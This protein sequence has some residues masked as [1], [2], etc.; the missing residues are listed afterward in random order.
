M[1]RRITFITSQKKTNILILNVMRK[2]LCILSEGKTQLSFILD[3]TVVGEE[4]LGESRRK[5]SK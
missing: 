2:N 1:I 3:Y 4:A 5:E